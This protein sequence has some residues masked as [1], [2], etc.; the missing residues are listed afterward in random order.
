MP[1][2]LLLLLLISAGVITPPAVEVVAGDYITPTQIGTLRVRGYN[3]FYHLERIGEEKIKAFLN[4]TS[5][6]YPNAT[7]WLIHYKLRLCMERLNESMTCINDSR[8]CEYC[9]REYARELC[10]CI[11]ACK[12]LNDTALLNLVLNA[13]S[14]HK[15]VLER[16]E[17]IIEKTN[18][19]PEVKEFVKSV[20]EYAK[21]RSM[22]GYCPLS[23][24]Q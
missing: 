12:R 2:W 9:M 10:E 8:A 21:E 20:I 11:N 1:L 5:T 22:K 17:E 14:H 18:M 7:N 13:T 4:F 16:V 15:K 6:F 24:S 23:P 19:P 3:F